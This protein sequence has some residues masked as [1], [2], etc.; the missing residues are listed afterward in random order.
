MNRK[1]KSELIQ[2]AMRLKH[3]EEYYFSTKLAEIARMRQLG[4]EVINLGIGS[5]DMPPAAKVIEEL[6]RSASDSR[7]HGYQGYRGIPALRNAFASWYMQYFN[8][9]LEPGTEILPLIGSKEGIMHISMAFLDPGDEV[10]VPDPG[11]PAYGA[12]AKLAGG[13]IRSYDLTEDNGWTPDIKAIEASGVERVKMMWINYPHMPSGARATPEI[14]E[15][16]VSFARRHSIL[17]CQDNPYSFILNKDYLSIFSVP[18]ARDVSLE[19]NSLSKSHNMAGWRIGMVAGNGSY[20]NEILKF[21]SNMDSGMFLPLQA[22]AVEALAAPEVWYDDLNEIYRRRRIIAAEIMKTL[23]C[24][25]D[26]V[27]AG[28]FLWGK[29]PSQ[30]PDAVEMT[31]KLLH[32]NHLFITPGSVFGENGKRYIRISLCA[33]EELL[34]AALERIRSKKNVTF[35]QTF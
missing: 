14:F 28:L 12:A 33:T 23:S 18:G 7:N 22:A 30:C 31:E 26:Q 3:V 16:L 34:T 11:Y 15:R 2:P 8:V 10:L 20:I 29:I 27:Q 21:K 19:L 5:P 25:F 4:I 13:T 9:K 35:N 24:T 17:L 1:M 32:E 6:G